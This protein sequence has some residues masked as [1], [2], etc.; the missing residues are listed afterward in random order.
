MQDG[1]RHTYFD[2]SENSDISGPDSSDTS[3][4]S[5]QNWNATTKTSTTDRGN[6]LLLYLIDVVTKTKVYCFYD[7]FEKLFVVV[8]LSLKETTTSFR[9]F[10]K[11]STPC[12]NFL[13]SIF[14]GNT[15]IISMY[16]HSNLVTETNMI[17]V[18]QIESTNCNVL[19]DFR[20][21]E[22]VVCA[23]STIKKGLSILKYAKSFWDF[24]NNQNTI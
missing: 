3:I 21:E 22:Y 4:N 9:Y 13:S 5:I 11:R 7:H 10:F 12:M 8:G 14:I 23:N 24:E 20:P 15:A 16:N 2:E 19:F 18:L 17:T 1:V 6:A